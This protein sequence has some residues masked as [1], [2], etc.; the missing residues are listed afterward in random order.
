M[1]TWSGGE[2]G[3]G[4]EAETGAPFRLVDH[5]TWDEAWRLREARLAVSTERATG[6]LRHE[7]D[8][9]GDGE[10]RWRNGKARAVPELD[11]GID[12][13]RIPSAIERPPAEA[14]AT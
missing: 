9:E 10:G 6:S 7:T 8:G 3:E 14:D 13:E 1:A 12:L 5:L 4:A 2:K 11:G